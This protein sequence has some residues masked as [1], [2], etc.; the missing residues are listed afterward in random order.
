M[1]AYSKPKKVNHPRYKYFVY[2]TD[3][4]NKRTYKAFKTLAE[5]Q[6]FSDLGNIQT[7]NA[8]FQVAGLSEEKRREF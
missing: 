6:N 5:A 3:E 1:K 2:Y 7:H 8:G 4:N